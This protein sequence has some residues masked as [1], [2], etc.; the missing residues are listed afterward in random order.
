MRVYTPMSRKRPIAAWLAVLAATS[1]LLACGGDDSSGTAPAAKPAQDV[2]TLARQAF[3]PNR[4]AARG[5]IDGHIDITVKGARGFGEPVRLAMSGPF[6]ARP[7]SALPDYAIDLS[8]GDQGVGLHSVQGRS[9]VSL[10][11]TGYEI[12][13]RIRRRLAR[14]A[15]RGRNG[16]TR[17]LEQFGIAPWRWETNKRV[18]ATERIGGVETVRVDTGVDVAR[19]LRDANTFGDVLGSL[20]LARANGL[21]SKIPRAARRALAASVRDA[22]GASWIATSDKVM[23]KAGLTI[24]FAVSPARRRAL[25]GIS[26]VKVVAEVLVTEVGARQRI[27]R[28]RS[29][30]PFASLQQAFDA[31]AESVGG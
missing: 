23:R 10:G 13:A 21:P 26:S 18:G 6:R 19:F 30:A 4:K 3:G 2:A 15:A 20:G 5:R 31:L 9:F 7:G 16:L 12:P 1:G 27:E 22:K 25:G 24:D 11:T 8:A 17:V 28:P 14:S 29:L